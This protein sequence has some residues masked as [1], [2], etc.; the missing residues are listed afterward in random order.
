[1]LYIIFINVIYNVVIYILYINKCES[2][3]SVCIATE[4]RVGRSGFESRWGPDSPPVQTGPGA[5]PFSCKMGTV[6]FPEV[7]AADHS[8]P[9]SAAVMEE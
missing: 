7:R 9:S 1:M 5:H 2:V 4:L 8:L 3:N 6:S